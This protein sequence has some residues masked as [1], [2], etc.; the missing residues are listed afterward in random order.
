MNWRRIITSM[1]CSG[2]PIQIAKESTSMFVHPPTK[3][4]FFTGGENEIE[5]EWAFIG[6]CMRE[7]YGCTLVS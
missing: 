1:G 6:E 7:S 3:I 4:C 2:R 5:N